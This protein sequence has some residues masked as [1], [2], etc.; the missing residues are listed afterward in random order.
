MYTKVTMNLVGAQ[1]RYET[2][3]GKQY[4]VVPTVML[5]E[6]VHAGSKGPLFYSKN[7]LS[8]NPVV[9]NHKPVVIYHP[10]LNGEGVTACDPNIVESQKVGTLFNTG[11]DGR[12]KTESWL[13]EEKLKRLD[14]R[15]LEAIQNGQMVEVSTGLYHDLDDTPGEFNGKKYTAVVTNIQ[16]DHLA[17]LPDEKGACSIADGAGLLRNADGGEMSLDDIRSLAQSVLRPERDKP[18][19]SDYC[20]VCEVYPKYFVYER[21]GTYY[22]V[23]YKVKNGKM[24]L[25]GE[26]EE[27]RKVTSYTTVNGRSL[28][29]ATQN[30]D[31]QGPVKSLVLPK[32]SADQLSSVMKHQQMQSALVKKYSGIQQDGDWGGWVTDLY[33]N[34]VVYSK[35]GKN[36]R[37]PYTYDDDM[38]RFDGEAEEVDRV[39]EYRTRTNTPI[40]GTCSPYSSQEPNTVNTAT[41]PATTNV[42]HQGTSQM[43]HDATHHDAHET[44]PAKGDSQQRTSAGGARK[45][46]VDKMIGGGHAKEEDRKFLMDLPDDH[47]AK[48]SSW[49]LKGAT[50]P[51]VP[52]TYDGIGDRSNAHTANSQQ[53]IEKYLQ[54][55]PP[56]MQGMVRNGLASYEAEKRKLVKAITSNKRNRFSEAWLMQI[57]DMEQLRGMA[58][59]ATGGMQQ[60]TNNYGGQADVPMFMNGQVQNVAGGEEEILPIPT[61]N[62]EKSK[63]A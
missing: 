42:M 46:S 44:D 43:I 18:Y 49:V 16:P 2:L 5:T 53:D 6:G 58:D 32:P 35:D 39:S 11:W 19:V 33:A 59:L 25:D 1:K 40:D 62:F 36:Y 48:V 55:L 26:P 27:V 12:L 31:V 61:M 28:A 37:L 24:T 15:V 4:L 63:T 29:R 34:F 38:I 57:Q 52:Y 3:E 56:V 9:W 8:K 50:E 7:Q 41:R 20:Y 14:N 60:P 21:D 54:G 17:I 22:K 30:E 13:D 47:F 51:I 10:T 23:G 45:D